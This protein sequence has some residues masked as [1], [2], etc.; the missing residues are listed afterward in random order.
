MRKSGVAMEEVKPSQGGCGIDGG[1]KCHDFF[2][3]VRA[4]FPPADH[5]RAGCGDYL[6][7]P[8]CSI[9]PSPDREVAIIL[10]ALCFLL[11]RVRR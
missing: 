4:L 1:R 2:E 10:R 11:D 3:A 6:L 8:F 9:V 5:A 7:F